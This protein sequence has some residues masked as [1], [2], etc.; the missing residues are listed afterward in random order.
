MARSSRF[1]WLH[2]LLAVMP[3]SPRHP[4][5]SLCML[6]NIS[7]N[8][9]VWLAC[10]KSALSGRGVPRWSAY[11]PTRQ[12]GVRYLRGSSGSAPPF[13][14]IHRLQKR[15]TS[16]GP[17]IHSPLVLVLFYCPL[18][19]ASAALLRHPLAFAGTAVHG[20]TLDRE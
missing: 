6:E 4:W 13:W 20:P 7:V 16:P 8:N 3:H 10:R 18:S 15:N 1:G 11:P 14:V 12:G 9:V 17:C 19:T 2:A 5:R